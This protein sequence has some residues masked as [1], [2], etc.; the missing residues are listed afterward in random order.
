MRFIAT[1]AINYPL[2]AVDNN[3]VIPSTGDLQVV[4]SLPFVKRIW[5]LYF[6]WRADILE[7]A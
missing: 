5:K 2:S 7:M 3:G 1:C 6:F 4:G